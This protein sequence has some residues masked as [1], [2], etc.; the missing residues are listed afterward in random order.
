M[1]TL[2]Y[3]IIIDMAGTAFVLRL[4]FRV[5]GIR[6]FFFDAVRTSAAYSPQTICQ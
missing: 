1:L 3:S 6:R 4:G 2:L 5:P